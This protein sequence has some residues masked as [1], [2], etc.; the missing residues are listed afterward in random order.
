M[1]TTLF[2]PAA[3]RKDQFEHW[4]HLTDSTYGPTSN[5]ALHEGDFHGRL[6]VA[7]LGPV[8]ISHMIAPTP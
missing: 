2:P 6:Q 8:Q 5:L 7:G 4:Q 1:G 3:S